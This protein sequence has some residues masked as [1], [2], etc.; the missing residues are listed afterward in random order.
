MKLFNKTGVLPIESNAQNLV[1]D[2][3]RLERTEQKDIEKIFS[4]IFSSED[5]A[6]ALSY[7]QTITFHRALG[8]QSSD[9][10]LRH[11][12]GQRTMVATILRLVDRGR[13]G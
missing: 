4:R 11:L 13:H 6:K 2:A 8:A 9:C 3:A 12:E 10:E 5:G 7:L 1:Y